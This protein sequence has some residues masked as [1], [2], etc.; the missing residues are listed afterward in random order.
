MRIRERLTRLEQHVPTRRGG[1]A[2][3]PQSSG[4]YVDVSLC[5]FNH[6]A[7]GLDAPSFVRRYSRAEVV[8][9]GVTL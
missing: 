3:C 7:S 9:L 8:A 5:V 1:A 4:E 6:S 2:F